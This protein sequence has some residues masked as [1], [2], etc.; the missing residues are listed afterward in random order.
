MSVY[1]MLHATHKLTSSSYV[2]LCSL[3]THRTRPS[4]SVS[5]QLQRAAKSSRFEDST[6]STS[7]GRDAYQFKSDAGCMADG[8]GADLG[9]RVASA[10]DMV[11]EGCELHAGTLQPDGQRRMCLCGRSLSRQ[12]GIG[13]IPQLLLLSR[14]NCTDLARLCTPCLAGIPFQLR[15]H[16]RQ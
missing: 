10:A 6:R 3:N 12:P 14:A 1:V 2:R 13:E 5:C 15:W 11:K 16:C 4:T 7:T 8:G 9:L